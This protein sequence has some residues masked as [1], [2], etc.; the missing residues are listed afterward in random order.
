M[1]EMVALE[2]ISA[3][4]LDETKPLSATMRCIAPNMFEFRL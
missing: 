4:G 1:K 3:V 2:T